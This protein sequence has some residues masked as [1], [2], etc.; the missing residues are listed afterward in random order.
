MLLKKLKLYTELVLETVYW[1]FIYGLLCTVCTRPWLM[2][3][4]IWT[5]CISPLST[6]VIFTSETLHW[7]TGSTVKLTILFE[8]APGNLIYVW[9]YLQQVFVLVCF[10]YSNFL[11]LPRYHLLTQTQIDFEQVNVIVFNV[12]LIW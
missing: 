1:V 6:K 12:Y 4:V 5:F 2:S 8:N 11:W 9:Q 3:K 7:T 10:N